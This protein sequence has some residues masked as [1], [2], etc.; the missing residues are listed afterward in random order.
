MPKII[1]EPKSFSFLALNFGQDIAAVCT[2]YQKSCEL[3][4]RELT[5][6]LAQIMVGHCKS[7]GV[8]IRDVANILDTCWRQTT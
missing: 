4:D 2:R 8:E 6:M 5:I 1:K 3:S 7:A